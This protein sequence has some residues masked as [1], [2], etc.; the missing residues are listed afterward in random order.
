M[1]NR[2]RGEKGSSRSAVEVCGDARGNNGP[3]NQRRLEAQKGL[4]YVLRIGRLARLGPSREQV[5]KKSMTGT[6]RRC[7]SRLLIC[8]TLQELAMDLGDSTNEAESCRMLVAKG[9][10]PSRTG[11]CWLTSRRKDTRACMSLAIQPLRGL[12]GAGRECE[13]R[14]FEGA[15]DV[16]RLIGPAE[17][18]AASLI[19]RLKPIITRSGGW[20]RPETWTIHG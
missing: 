1:S 13:R 5:L 4:E 18:I 7:D 17:V 15:H 11:H 14:G 6:T 9:A 12:D 3:I 10:D 20:V 16:G 2:E 19:T 8:W